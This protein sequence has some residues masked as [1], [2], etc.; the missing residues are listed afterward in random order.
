M[1]ILD[2]DATACGIGA[3]LS[4]LQDGKEVVSANAVKPSQGLRWDIVQLIES[5]W[6]WLRFETGPALFI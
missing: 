3:V 2:T 5:C 4:Q 6:R 1:F